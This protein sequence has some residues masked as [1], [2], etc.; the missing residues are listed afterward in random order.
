MSGY[1]FENWLRN[2][3]GYVIHEKEIPLIANRYSKYGDYNIHKD[4]FLAEV[5]ASPDSERE[6]VDESGE[7]HELE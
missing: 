2:A 6:E 4:K 1:R 5:N 7:A 3:C